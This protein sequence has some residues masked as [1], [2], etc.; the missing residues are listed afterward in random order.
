VVQLG[1]QARQ[2]VLGHAEAREKGNVLYI[3]T[4]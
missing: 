4:G 3:R 1:L 2:L